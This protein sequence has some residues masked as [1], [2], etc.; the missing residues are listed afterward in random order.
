MTITVAE[1]VES[2]VEALP[3]QIRLHFVDDLV[4]SAA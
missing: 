1:D 3:Q 4:L 2:F